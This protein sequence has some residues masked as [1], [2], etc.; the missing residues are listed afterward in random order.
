[1][2]HKEPIKIETIIEAELDSVAGL[3]PRQ[4]KEKHGV[5]ARDLN[6]A[7]E[8]ISEVMDS[9][10]PI[11]SVDRKIISEAITDRLRPIKEDL[12]V[13][14]LEIIKKAD[15]LIVDRMTSTPEDVKT[16]DL[17]TISDTHSK[18][19]ARIVGIEEDPDGGGD[20]DPNKRAKNINVFIE[21]AFMGHNEKLKRE[22]ETIN[23]TPDPTIIEGELTEEGK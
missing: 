11:L 13:K 20:G 15:D 17:I 1:M 16:K 12:A 5:S 14:S 7:K 19:L 23:A 10:L 18:R 3:T 8:R 9:T 2:S 6:K 4:I 22:R 21:N